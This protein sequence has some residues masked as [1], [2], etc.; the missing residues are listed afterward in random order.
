[1][2]RSGTGAA[3]PQAHRIA[4]SVKV[5]SNAQEEEKSGDDILELKS[6]EKIK[7]LNS[8]CIGNG[9]KDNMPVLSGKVGDKTIEVLQ[10][11]RCCGVIVN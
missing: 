10:D 9:R 4:C 1:M 2:P 8:A 7:V 3:K 11:T 5:Q 6:G